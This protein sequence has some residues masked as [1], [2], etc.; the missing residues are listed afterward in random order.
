M[1]LLVTPPPFIKKERT[2]HK[3][4]WRVVFALLPP[5]VAAAY[6]FKAQAIIVFSS[7]IISCILTEAL[8]QRARGKKVTVNDGTAIITALILGLLL[9]YNTPFWIPFIGGVF[10]IGIVKQAFGGH[11]YN[12]FNPAVAGWVFLMIS[13]ATLTLP[14]PAEYISIEYFFL[15]HQA[16][17]LVEASPAFVL[18]GGLFLF[19][20]RLIKV[21]VPFGFLLGVSLPLIAL[22]TPFSKLYTGIF[23]LFLFFIITDPVTS[24]ITKWG[25][26]MYGVACGLLVVVYSGY[27]NYEDGLG[28][29]ILL[30]NALVPLI[31]RHTK[32]TPILLEAMDV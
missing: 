21:D 4:I 2:A 30:M 1:N 14:P 32:P 19:L 24:P 13:W 23:I 26:L 27:A 25:R 7:S 12:V 18:L 3:V 31:D 10:A 9:P 20:T 5:V 28:L 29:S 6:L 15:N 11:G 22:R 17:R 16:V 8:V